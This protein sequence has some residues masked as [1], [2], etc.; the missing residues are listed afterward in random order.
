MFIRHLLKPPMDMDHQSQADLPN[1]S[2][3]KA[4]YGPLNDAGFVSQLYQ[5]VLSRVPDTSEL[6]AWLNLM[7]NGDSNGTLFTRDMV[8]VGVAESS[9][10][11]A[12]TAADWLIQI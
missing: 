11:I 9:E 7:H 5:N 6:N 10:N 4:K 1:Q 3:F 2:S 8:L 12:K